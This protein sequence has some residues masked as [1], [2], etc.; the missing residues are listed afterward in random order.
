MIRSRIQTGDAIEFSGDAAISRL[1]M[2]RTGYDVSHS[3]SVIVA[4]FP[5]GTRVQTLES[6]S[7]GVV[8]NFLSARLND[9]K[10]KAYWLPLKP[11]FDYLRLDIEREMLKLCA[12]KKKRYD[13]T[14]IGKMLIF[15][16][17]KV[18]LSTL[19]CTEFCYVPLRNIGIAPILK[20]GPVPGELVKLGC[21]LN[22]VRIL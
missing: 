16:K 14:S 21:Y 6:L 11:E 22:R 15:G 10:G 13:Y 3:T 17:T 5:S 12:D 2:L 9:Y 19:W 20:Y 4:P 18:D 8:P 7:S 1:I